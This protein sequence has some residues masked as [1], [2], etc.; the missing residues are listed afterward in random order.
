MHRRVII[1]LL[2][3]ALVN[4]MFFPEKN[5]N[6]HSSYAFSGLEEINSILEY[7]D[8]VYFGAPDFTPEDEDDDIPDPLKGATTLDWSPCTFY[9]YCSFDFK[10]AKK[11]MTGF[12]QV[13]AEDSQ[14]EIT[15][16][17]P[18]VC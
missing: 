18:E 8:E 14:I 13:A 2:L 5:I 4:T 12:R 3:I 9:T 1:Y 6:Q 10:A 11:H 16:L 15:L 17:P 7:L